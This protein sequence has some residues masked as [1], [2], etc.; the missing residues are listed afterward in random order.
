MIVYRY[1]TMDEIL[2]FINGRFENIGSAYPKSID[3][4]THRYKPNQKYLHFFKNLGDLE[5]IKR[6]IQK[7]GEMLIAK[8]DIPFFTLAKHMGIGYY[9][10]SGYDFDCNYIREFAI[11]TTKLKAEYFVS[12]AKDKDGLMTSEKAEESLKRFEELLK[13][14]REK[15]KEMGEE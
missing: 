15:K 10:P 1:L 6:S 8:F 5:A 4:N 7:N 13:E 9:E 11:P 12:C 2:D 3:N 14:H